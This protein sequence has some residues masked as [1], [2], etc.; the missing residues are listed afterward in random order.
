[1]EIERK[2]RTELESQA[3]DLIKSAKQKW[4]V[5]EKSKL[6]ALNTQIDYLKEKMNTLYDENNT[7][8]DNLKL[9]KQL[10][11]THKVISNH[12]VKIHFT[13]LSPQNSRFHSKKSKN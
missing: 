9:A 1:M 13:N 2:D 3:L 11:N 7:L 10:E 8:K 5:S 12:I 6:E 4:E